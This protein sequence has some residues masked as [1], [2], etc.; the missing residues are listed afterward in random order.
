MKDLKLYQK[1]VGRIY[2]NCEQSD[3]PIK[4]YWNKVEHLVLQWLECNDT[5]SCDEIDLFCSNVEK[6]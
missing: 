2:S 6:Y 1:M 5:S 3:S 4:I